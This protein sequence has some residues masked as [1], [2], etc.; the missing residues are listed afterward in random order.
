MLVLSRKRGESI[1]IESDIEIEVLEIRKGRVRLGIRAPRTRR[2][3]RAE[4]AERE[5]TADKSA[6]RPETSEVHSG[7]RRAGS[8]FFSAGINPCR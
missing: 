6:P 7:L 1:A 2:I 5:T 3:I 4:V 8:A